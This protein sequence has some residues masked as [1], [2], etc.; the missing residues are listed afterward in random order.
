MHMLLVIA[1]G[2]ILLG[3]FA[4]FGKLWGADVA[5]IAAGAR[6]FIPVWLVVAITNMWVGVTKAGYTVAQELPILAVVFIVPA[7]LAAALAWQLAK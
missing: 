7:I 3:V 1:G 5:G 4:L 2:V 6:L